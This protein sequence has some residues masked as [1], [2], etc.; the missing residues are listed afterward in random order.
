M[1]N[2]APIF[3]DLEIQQTC[4]VPAAFQ[5]K[6]GAGAQKSQAI[7]YRKPCQTQFEAFLDASFSSEVNPAAN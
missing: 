3:S 5:A 6:N 1:R 4:S 7:H 2:T